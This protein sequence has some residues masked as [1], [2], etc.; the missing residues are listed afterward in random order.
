MLQSFISHNLFVMKRNYI[1]ISF[2]LLFA[3]ISSGTLAQSDSIVGTIKQLSKED[4]P[5]KFNLNDEGSHW[6]Q[7]TLLNQTWVRYNQSNPGTTVLTQPKDNTFDIG[8][9]RTRIQMYGQITDRAFLY[10]QFGQNNFNFLANGQGSGNRIISA[11]FHDALCEYRVSKGNQLKLGGGLTIANGLSRF[12]NPSVGT[13]L[14]LD[15]PVFAQ[16]TVNATDQFSRK[17]SVYARGQINKID[18][19]LILSDPFP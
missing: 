4:K 10:F 16:A 14:S 9:R 15:V 18:Y 11:Y 12:S 19:R 7:V 6:F 2:A 1:K 5:L 8:L 17:L 3:F 13:I